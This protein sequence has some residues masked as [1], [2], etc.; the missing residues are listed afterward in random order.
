[1]IEKYKLVTSNKIALIEALE[2]MLSQNEAVQVTAKPWSGKRSLPANAQVYVWYAHIAKLEGE[3]AES[4]RNFC[5]LMFGLPI[6]LQDENYSNKIS[7]TLNKLGFYNW[8]HEQQVNYMEL[9]PVSSL[10]N[11]KQHNEYRDNMQAY[12]AKNGVMLD[13]VN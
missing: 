12:Y 11:T 2:V 6:L 8:N 4:V 1:M 10:F 13:Y 3:S 9:L 5:K 7:W